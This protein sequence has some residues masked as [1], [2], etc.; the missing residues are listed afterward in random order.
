VN[1]TNDQLTYDT[2]DG[3]LR[4]RRNSAKAIRREAS[5]EMTEK[6][7]GGGGEK[8]KEEETK[9]R[10]H[11]PSPPMRGKISTSRSRRMTVTIST[12]SWIPREGSQLEVH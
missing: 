1:P 5:G 12:T 4:A 9:E 8:T 11:S 2:S 10:A 3:I 7:R 6:L